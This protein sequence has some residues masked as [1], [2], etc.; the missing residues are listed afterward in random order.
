MR[1]SRHTIRPE[2]VHRRRRWTASPPSHAVGRPYPVI[3]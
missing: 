2:D 1:R 3:A